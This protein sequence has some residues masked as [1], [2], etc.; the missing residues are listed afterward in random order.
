MSVEKYRKYEKKRKRNMTNLFQHILIIS[1]RPERF[2]ACCERCGFSESDKK[3]SAVVKV[4]SVNGTTLNLD[5][6]L[7]TGQVK[8]S[9]DPA[10]PPLTRGQIGCFMSHRNAWK[11]IID[12]HLESALILEDDIDFGKMTLD[13]FKTTHNQKWIN[14]QSEM[15]AHNYKWDILYLGRNEKVAINFR[16]LSSELTIPGLSWG[17]FSYVIKKRA[18][19][20]LYDLSKNQITEAVDTWVST[21]PKIRKSL[22]F[23]AFSPSLT[24]IVNVKSDTVGII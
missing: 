21:C 22:F 5:D 12:H 11:Y 19:Q 24:T 14:L 9:D 15:K 10:I 17:L 2:R 16:R 4:D 6:L 1:I 8:N 13:Q 18:A 3:D 20:F 7:R 23:A